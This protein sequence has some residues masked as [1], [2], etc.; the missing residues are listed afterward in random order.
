MVKE[1]LVIEFVFSKIETKNSILNK[2]SEE[3]YKS[4]I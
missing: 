1:F 3:D 2:I 4:W